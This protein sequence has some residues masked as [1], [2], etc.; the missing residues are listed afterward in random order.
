MAEG[1][2]GMKAA[3]GA[4]AKLPCESR[5]AR[6][7]GRF[8]RRARVVSFVSLS[9]GPVYRRDVF[10][11][12]LSSLVLDD[13]DLQIFALHDQRRLP[14]DIEPFEQSGD[15]LRQRFLRGCRQRGERLV[16]RPV[17]V[18]E[19]LEPNSQVE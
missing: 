7:A 12:H 15:V 18:A 14:C 13:H 8:H 1:W 4:K 6:A 5:G 16:R 2:R 3:T 11:A 19:D 17:E 9:R 10:I